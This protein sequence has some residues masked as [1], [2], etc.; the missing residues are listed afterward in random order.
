MAGHEWVPSTLGH[1]NQMCRRCWTT[2]LEA[3]ALG[4]MDY[5]AEASK[6][7]KPANDDKVK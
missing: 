2:D 6:P 5:C 7:P 3:M 4:D 1:G